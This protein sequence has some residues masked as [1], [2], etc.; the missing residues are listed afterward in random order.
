LTVF[1]NE[2]SD[3]GKKA[4]QKLWDRK[5]KGYRCATLQFLWLET[6]TLVYAQFERLRGNNE[7]FDSEDRCPATGHIDCDNAN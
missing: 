7:L 3:E 6:D 1:T 2:H 5:I 4:Q